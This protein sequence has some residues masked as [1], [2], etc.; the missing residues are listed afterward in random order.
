MADSDESTGSGHNVRASTKAKT[1]L[2]EQNQA[3]REEAK[4]KKKH[5]LV[6]VN[7]VKS[8]PSTAKISP[9]VANAQVSPATPHKTLPVSSPT[10]SP[11]SLHHLYGTQT[12]FGVPR[13]RTPSTLTRDGKKSAEVT[14]E[15]VSDEIENS[16]RS[17]S[18]DSNKSSSKQSPEAVV[19]ASGIPGVDIH[20]SPKSTDKTDTFEQEES[21]VSTES[22]KVEGESEELTSEQEAQIWLEKLYPIRGKWISLF[23]L[24]N[25]LKFPLAEACYTLAWV[26]EIQQ[27]DVIICPMLYARMMEYV[28]TWETALALVIHRM[29]SMPAEFGGEWIDI[30]GKPEIYIPTEDEIAKGDTSVIGKRKTK[31][32][33]PD[34]QSPKSGQGKK[35]IF[36]PD[37]PVFEPKSD[38]L[39]N[40]ASA[41]VEK[42]KTVNPMAASYDKVPGL[43]VQN[44]VYTKPITKKS[45]V[46]PDHNDWCVNCHVADT[47]DH[48]LIYKNETT[49]RFVEL[50]EVERLVPAY[51]EDKLYYHPGVGYFQ[52]V[53]IDADLENPAF[54]GV[55]CMPE[56]FGYIADRPT[57]MVKVAVTGLSVPVDVLE[58][59][60][61][62]RKQKAKNES[63]AAT[64]N[65][66]I[67]E[68]VIPDKLA[69]EFFTPAKSGAFSSF[70]SA[71]KMSVT[72]TNAS[73]SSARSNTSCM[74]AAAL[75]FA[76][77]SKT[78]DAGAGRRR[79]SV[80]PSTSTQ[81]LEGKVEAPPSVDNLAGNDENDDLDDAEHLDSVNSS[82]RD[83]R[84]SKYPRPYY[85]GLISK[86]EATVFIEKMR[87]YRL[88]RG[89]NWKRLLITEMEIMLEG[90][91]L[92][93]YKVV[94]NAN[95]I[96]TEE[97]F[98]D[99]FF[100]QYVSKDYKLQFDEEIRDRF[101][102]EDESATEFVAIMLKAYEL[103]K[104]EASVAEKLH[105]IKNNFTGVYFDR[106]AVYVFD[107][108]YQLVD[109]AQQVDSAM[110]HRDKP[111]VTDKS[112]QRVL[113][114]LGAPIVP[115]DP[116][117]K[118]RNRRLRIDPVYKSH[119]LSKA[120]MKKDEHLFYEMPLASETKAGKKFPSQVPNVTNTFKSRLSGKNYKVSPQ[121]TFQFAP[122][123]GYNKPPWKSQNP[124]YG[125]QSNTGFKGGNT[126]NQ[127]NANPQRNANF[128]K[129]NYKQNNT[130][131]QNTGNKPQSSNT[132]TEKIPKVM[133]LNLGGDEVEEVLV[134]S[135]DECDYE[136]GSE[137]QSENP[138]AA[139]PSG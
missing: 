4:A 10:I 130:N 95:R 97:E 8:G 132:N 105:L 11:S 76:S 138:E 37:A 42:T 50:K 7:L 21:F 120:T 3:A 6:D 86:L 58:R 66:G 19:I 23:H 114:S 24:V 41:T 62:E 118:E 78:K 54:N 68:K 61:F 26:Q 98:I 59:V 73:R 104:P 123:G 31:V 134:E 89:L 56:G 108:E 44:S 34:L 27:K 136:N 88:L 12:L 127:Q 101:L 75:H 60:H 74:S 67:Q 49:G 115:G 79:T 28:I 111:K 39:D 15:R 103:Y 55:L 38:C 16:P 45:G 129:P 137:S 57:Q 133:L 92:T 35:E 25:S 82:Q 91:A 102:G 121:S 110:A 131:S 22:G 117:N 135:E 69:S 43:D 48:C 46:N 71:S 87:K 139:Q 99:E 100:C 85:G 107:T 96:N 1:L 63:E 90:P 94:L 109:A 128:Q 20:I 13:T 2:A 14:P 77:G 84:G 32:K 72:N 113:G 112:R 52:V 70:T 18:S 106:M 126:T 122:R 30:Q 17:S 51:K 119:E 124:N 5:R 93:W 116:E 40:T 33:L 81:V 65:I 80:A 9:V 29:D 53:G 83:Y 125:Q 47:P 64:V 36:N